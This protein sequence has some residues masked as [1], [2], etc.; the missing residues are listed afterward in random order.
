MAGAMGTFSYTSDNGTVYRIRLDA[1]NAAALGA[2]PA[3]GPSNLPGRTKPR[4]VLLQHPTTGRERKIVACNIADPVWLG[5][6]NLVTI[7]DFSTE[8]SAPVEYVAL[9]RIGER[10]LG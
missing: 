10:R 5:T 9:G 3:V 1:G 8:P 4:Y 2:T 7:T 6:D